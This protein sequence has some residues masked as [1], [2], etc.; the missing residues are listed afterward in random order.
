MGKKYNDTEG[1]RVEWIESEEKG[2]ES[3]S[4]RGG[5]RRRIES[6]SESLWRGSLLIVSCGLRSRR[7]GERIYHPGRHVVGR[8]YSA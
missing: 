8:D 1:E 7:R 3:R 2:S 5:G 6:T 4:P